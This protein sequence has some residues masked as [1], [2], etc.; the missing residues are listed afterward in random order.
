MLGCTRIKYEGTIVITSGFMETHPR[1]SSLNGE[2]PRSSTD[3]RV[4]TIE[5]QSQY[6]YAYNRYPLSSSKVGVGF[7]LLLPT[8]KMS[9]PQ[10]GIHLV[11]AK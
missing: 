3:I 2:A 7:R 8:S 6:C 5:Y 10:H 9:F 1:E 11:V 4:P